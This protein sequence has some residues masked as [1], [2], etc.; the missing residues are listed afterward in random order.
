MRRVLPAVIQALAFSRMAVGSIDPIKTAGQPLPEPGTFAVG[1][2]AARPRQPGYSLDTQLG[3]DCVT[4]AASLIRSKAVSSKAVGFLA[5]R[6]GCVSQCL[7][8][9]IA[10][11]LKSLV[12]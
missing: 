9:W 11:K 8:G 7:Q 4:G 3:Y 12:N 10:R 1:A 2:P 5:E 6:E